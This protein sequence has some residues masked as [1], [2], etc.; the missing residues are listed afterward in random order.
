MTAP[1]GGTGASRGA[2]TIS[3]RAVWQGAVIAALVV[4]LVAGLFLLIWLVAYALALLFA[5]IVLANALGPVVRRFERW[6]PPAGAV[7]LTYALLVVTI[8]AIGWLVLPRLLVQGREVVSVGPAMFGQFQDWL[9]RL[10]PGLALRAAESLGPLVSEAAAELLRVPLALVRFAAGALL[11]LI[12]AVYWSLGSDALRRYVFSLVPRHL[13]DE[14]AEVAAEVVDTIG[15]YLRARV[16]VGG[17]VGVVV[18]IG[19][20]LLGVEYPLVLGVL[21]AFGELIPYLGPTVAAAPAVALAL[22]K[23]PWE[24]GSVLVLY[25]A[26]QQAKALLLIPA[27]VRHHANIPPLLVV[28]ALVAGT[29][30]GGVIGGIVAPPLV[31]ALRIVVLRIVTPPIRRWAD[32]SPLGADDAVAVRPGDD[33]RPPQVTGDTPPSAPR[34]VGPAC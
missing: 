3:A 13:R 7:V 6:L 18:A 1:A 25:I 19:L 32:A 14:A 11:V 9:D 23:S 2:R 24:A 34:S 16:I 30:V 26:V 27:L 33:G 4:V 22:S 20:M 15:G 29:S 17:I 21:A 5:A 8:G 12:M 10:V 28:L 31:G